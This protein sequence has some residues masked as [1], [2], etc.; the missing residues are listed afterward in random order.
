MRGIW[1]RFTR[2]DGMTIV[3][4]LIAATILFIVLTAIL[5]LVLQT[6]NTGMQSKRQTLVTNTVSSYI[7]QVQAMPFEDVDLIADG[8]QLAPSETTTV[9]GYTIVI[10]PTITPGATSDLK[11]L[12]VSATMSLPN[13]ETTAA[14]LDVVI[15]D[16]SSFLTQGVSGPVVSWTTAVMPGEGEIV[17]ANTKASGGALWLAAEATAAEG[18]TISRV[19]ITADNGW[20]LENTIG[21]PAVWDFETDE[22]EQSWSLTG[23]AWNTE[24]EGII[25]AET[26]EVG[27]VIPDGMRTIKID[28]TDSGGGNTERTYTF[29]VDNLAPSTPGIP[30]Q[31]LASTGSIASWAAA[32]D[33]TDAVASYAVGLT[34]QAIGG[35]WARVASTVGTTQV[36][37]EPFKRYLVD[38]AAVGVNPLPATRGPRVSAS[39]AAPHSFIT[40]PRASGTRTV[41]GNGSKKKYLVSM[42]VPAP[43]FQ[44]SGTPTYRW[45]SSPSASGPWSTL[46]ASTQSVTDL[47]FAGS[48]LYYRC[49]VT[50]SPSVDYDGSATS[51]ITIGSSVLGPTSTAAAT[52][53]PLAEQWLQ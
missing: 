42:S 45:Y 1:G 18:Q 23:F 38:V 2:D 43:Q 47:S 46:V 44:V 50:L 7:E 26:L 21:T 14:S 24:Q 37:L 9:D 4:I 15:R 8:G 10:T 3:E 6:T 34:G 53:V 20:A 22:R 11:K 31:G 28:V 36:A 33:G 19:T 27:P 12:V 32:S 41:S 51:Q 30:T 13:G 17:W 39:V 40:P 49:F 29:L 5:G 16:K 25:D 35:S 52:A 48:V